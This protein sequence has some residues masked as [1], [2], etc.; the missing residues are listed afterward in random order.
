L[1]A[2]V[3]VIRSGRDRGADLGEAE[4]SV[5]TSAGPGCSPRTTV[6]SVSGEAGHSEDES[7]A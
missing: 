3:R 2:R 4:V 1:H 6:T 7:A 5:G